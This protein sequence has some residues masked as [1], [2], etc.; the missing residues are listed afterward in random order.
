ML[1]LI[2][3]VIISSFRTVGTMLVFAFIVAPPATAR[4]CPAGCRS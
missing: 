3:M 1:A 2:A 4:S